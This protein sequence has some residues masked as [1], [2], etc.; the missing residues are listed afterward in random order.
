MFSYYGSKSKIAGK[1]PE[2]KYE[3]IIEPFAGSAQYSFFGE[4]WSRNVI[5]IEKHKVIADLWSWLIHDAKEDE[6]LSAPTFQPKERIDGGLNG[7]LRSL[8]ALESNMGTET[9]RNVAGKPNFNRWS[10]NGRQRIAENLHKIRHWSVVNT[11]YRNAPDIEATWFIDP[12]YQFGGHEYT[13]GGS[14]FDYPGL[15]DWIET[16]RGQVI[17]CENTQATWAPFQPLVAVYGQR[18]HTTEAIWLPLETRCF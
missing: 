18:F 9:P 3:T 14:G 6:I 10:K 17:V 16:R 13:E 1:Y 4:R 5:L 12:P 7:C 8:A 15:R 11:D 2:P